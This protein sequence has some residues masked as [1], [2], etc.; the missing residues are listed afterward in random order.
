V[1]TTNAGLTANPNGG[2][3]TLP[4]TITLRNNNSAAVNWSMSVTGV[5]GTV[6]VTPAK[7]TLKPG[8]SVR[9]SVKATSS[10]AAGQTVTLSPGSTSWIVIIGFGGSSNGGG[11]GLPSGLI[12]SPAALLP[13]ASP[14]SVPVTAGAP[15][16]AVT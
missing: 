15:V 8:K 4:T 6:S 13:A 9:V 14:V 7:G 11:T 12:S 2:V 10:F 3:L 16:A 5:S 1:P